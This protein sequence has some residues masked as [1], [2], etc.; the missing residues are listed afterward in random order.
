ME[1]IG[2]GGVGGQLSLMYDRKTRI[3]QRRLEVRIRM[4]AVGCG[5]EG[6]EGEWRLGAYHGPVRGQVLGAFLLLS[7][8]ALQCMH[9]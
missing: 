2:K 1:G 7:L 3:G 5:G 9:K 6:K 8:L 4:G